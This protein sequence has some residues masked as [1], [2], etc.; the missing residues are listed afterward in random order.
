[1]KA[2]KPKNKK[3]L[4]Y[5]YFVM[6]IAL[7]AFNLFVTPMIQNQRI[8][9]VGYSDLIAALEEKQVDEVEVDNQTGKIAYTIK[10]NRKNVFVT[11]IM[12]NDAT[13]TERLEQSGAKYTAV[14]P[15][16]NSFLMDMLMWLVP[17]IIILG[18][19]QLFSKQLAK[20]M[21]ANTMTFGKSSAKIYVSAETG[22]T[23]QDVAGQ[24]EAK[25]AL[26]EIVDFL[27]NPDKYKKL[28]AKMPK[29]ALLVG[30]PG[31]GKTLLAKAVAGEANV[32][33]FSISGSEFVE[34]FVGMGAARVR[35]LFKQ[36]QEKA[37]CIVFIDE[38]DTI[39]KKRDSANGMGGNDER[40]QTL[41]QLLA[42]MD[43][44][45]GSKGVVI[46]A[47]T[48]RPETLDKALLRPGRFDRRIPVEL[49]DLKGREEILKVHVKDIVV[50]SDIDYRTIALSTSGASGAELANIVNEA[51]LA[52]VRNGHSKVMQHDFDEAV[53]TVI[54]GKERKG[55]VI[56]EKEK[57]IIA[58]HEIGHALVA[59]VSKNSA[60]VHKI[61]II[62][63]TN[64]S[65]GYT[66]QVAEQ[67]S[68]LMS[69]DEILEKI[70]TLTGGRAAEEFMFNICTSGAS[71]DIEQATR[72]A[73]AMVAQLGMSDQ[74][75][76]TALET[77]NNRYLSGDASLVC[78]NETA[79]LIDKEVMAII[80]NAHAEARK[81]LEDNA[82][83]LHEEA[84]YL[85]QKETITGE[86][87]MEIFSRHQQLKAL[88][89]PSEE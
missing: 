81:I 13:L 42:E 11:G 23:F 79:T 4:I 25:E 41:N 75:G 38:I 49:P 82:Q 77:V 54:A 58:Y 52:A 14:I 68:V 74:F 55:A 37:P 57:R 29:G 47:A 76:M 86:E 44:F 36:A 28:G 40:E 56:S 85:L 50:D 24:D 16:Q 39:G 84:E 51:A 62:P 21:G 83:L 48:N 26:S 63:H 22:K 46:L 45:D 65:L 10:D 9:E 17:I 73:R 1:M 32:P 78:S 34:M 3:P 31:T 33:F 30:P 87:F 66:M 2:E 59:A 19:G 27:H 88:P 15:Q 7:M 70:R 72:L 64:G 35:D 69:K 20:K 43:G 60:P 6:M 71:N 8:K 53:D 67:E 12:P 80:K 5:Y 61:T 89:Q 18:V